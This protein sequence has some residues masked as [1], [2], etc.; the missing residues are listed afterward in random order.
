[1]SIAQGLCDYNG[2]LYAAWKGD[3]GDDELYCA[4]LEGNVWAKKDSLPGN[5]S[6]G[7]ALVAANGLMYAA[8]REAADDESLYYASFDGNK[9]SDRMPIQLNGANAPASSNIG[10]SLAASGNTL[11]ASWVG[12]N[13]LDWLGGPHNLC[14][15]FASLD[16]TSSSAQWTLLPAI[17]YA[18]TSSIGPSITVI[19]GTLYAAWM[20]AF[21]GHLR[22]A[23]FGD[24]EWRFQGPIELSNVANPG[25]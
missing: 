12:Q 6:V 21:F 11:Y 5:S 13:I 22:Y 2:S 23:W 18:T 9:W 3:V 10:P 25:Q 1:M 7:P 15:T 4:V 20:D 8:W 17:P 19:G 16:T 14:F 24:G